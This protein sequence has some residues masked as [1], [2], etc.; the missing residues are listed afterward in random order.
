MPSTTYICSLHT[1]SCFSSKQPVTSCD[2]VPRVAT[3]IRM[4]LKVPRTLLFPPIHSRAEISRR[5]VVNHHCS[6]PRLPHGSTSFSPSFPQ[7]LDHLEEA[8]DRFDVN[9][10][11]SVPR[12]PRSL[13]LPP[14]QSFLRCCS[15][16]S[17]AQSDTC[18]QYHRL[19]RCCV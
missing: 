3:C 15:C 18:R 7:S 5:F 12:V 8:I 9:H 16:R 4:F 1:S 6:V 19:G 11:S 2:P 13:S 17:V 14:S 10:H